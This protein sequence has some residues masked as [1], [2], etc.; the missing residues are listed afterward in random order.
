MTNK[1]PYELRFDLLT[2]AR[3][4]LEAE[5][6]AA[7]NVAMERNKLHQRTDLPTYP[8]HKQIFDLAEE[9]KNFIEKK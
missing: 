6:H 2:F 7:L 8:T 9:Y 4:T 5:Y 3:D 1:T